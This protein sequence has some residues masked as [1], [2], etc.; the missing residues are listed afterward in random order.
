MS[1]AP[2]P[3]VPRP[4]FAHWL[5]RRRLTARAVAPH[6]GV[7]HEQVRRICLPYSDPDWRRPSDSLKAAVS[8]FTRG[9]VGDSDWKEPAAMGQAA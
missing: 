3:E 5:F 6:L 1:Q 7:S 4:K 2:L 9:E 8:N